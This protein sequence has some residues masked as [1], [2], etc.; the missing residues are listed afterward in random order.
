MFRILII[1]KEGGVY[2]DIKSYFGKL[3]YVIKKEDEFIYVSDKMVRC[4]K[5]PMGE[6]GNW[7]F[8]CTPR[9]PLLK[10]IIDQ[11]IYNIENYEKVHI[12]TD[13]D[14]VYMKHTGKDLNVMQTV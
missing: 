7:F 12:I 6:I 10:K 1:Y 4:E 5:F 11:V 8:G 13:Q 2:C 14:K 3:D 9:N